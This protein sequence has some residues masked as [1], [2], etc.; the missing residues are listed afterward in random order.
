M[1]QKADGGFESRKKESHFQPSDL[2]CYVIF[3]T[4][5][6][7]FGTRT[8]AILRYS[9]CVLFNISLN[10]KNWNVSVQMHYDLPWR[11]LIEIVE[12]LREQISLATAETHTQM[13]N[14]FFLLVYMWEVVIFRKALNLNQSSCPL[15]INRWMIFSH[16]LWMGKT[17]KMNFKKT[18]FYHYN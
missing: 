13:D 14:P 1:L 10:N 18:F 4:W 12:S 16:T 7:S 5:S 6:E 17:L 2:L 15:L 8:C 3:G 11:N 9:V